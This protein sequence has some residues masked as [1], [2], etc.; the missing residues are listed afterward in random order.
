MKSKLSLITV[1]TLCELMQY[2]ERHN[3][4]GDEELSIGV[5]NNV[6][7]MLSTLW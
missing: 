2:E 5:T 1:V 4:L 7:L 3:W 6:V